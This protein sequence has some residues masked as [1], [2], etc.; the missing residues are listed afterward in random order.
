MARNPQYTVHRSQRENRIRRQRILDVTVSAWNRILIF[1][2]QKKKI[3][4]LTLIFVDC[5]NGHHHGIPSDILGDGGYVRGDKFGSHVIYIP[6]DHR[7][8]KFNTINLPTYD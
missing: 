8:L 3:E 4:L 6:D 5:L 2:P 7:N 1:A